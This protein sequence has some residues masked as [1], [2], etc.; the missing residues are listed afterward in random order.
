MA[1][2]APLLSARRRIASALPLAPPSRRGAGRAGVLAGGRGLSLRAP[3][4]LRLSAVT[5]R[6]GAGGADDSSSAPPPVE[7]RMSTIYE[8]AG[9][10]FTDKY[11][12]V[13]PVYQRVYEWEKE[14][15]E[16]LLNDLES[17]LDTQ[18]DVNRLEVRL[19]APAT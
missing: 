15:V 7:R 19:A 4:R 12:F 2:A 9:K 18:Q 14:E 3:A 16:M 5:Q 8:Y 6:V 10:L 17:R 11:Q 1:A 13:I